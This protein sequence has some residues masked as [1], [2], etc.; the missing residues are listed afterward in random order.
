[1]KKV[2]IRKRFRFGKIMKEILW[3]LFYF[4][5]IISSFFVMVGLHNIDLGYNMRGLNAE[6]GLSLEDTSDGG[7]TFK[8]HTVVY[9]TG[10]DQVI[11]WFFAGMYGIFGFMV[12]NKR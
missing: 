7:K 9:N 5:P 10:V 2:N 4:L 11:I 3:T 6:H 8:S 1:M 12:L